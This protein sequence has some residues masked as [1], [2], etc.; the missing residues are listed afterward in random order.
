MLLENWGLKLQPLTECS[1]CLYCYKISHPKS[2]CFKTFIIVPHSS[3]DWAPQASSHTDNGLGLPSDGG[4]NRRRL[5]DPSLSWDE[6]LRRLTGFP[7]PSLCDITWQ[8]ESIFQVA[9]VTYLEGATKSKDL[10]IL[11]DRLLP[12]PPA[13]SQLFQKHGWWEYMKPLRGNKHMKPTHP[14]WYKLKDPQQYPHQ[15]GVL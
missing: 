4:Q 9:P 14:S 10:C 11:K 1:P 13:A 7:T 2:L 12:R 5:T 6:R 3:A 8:K 15:I